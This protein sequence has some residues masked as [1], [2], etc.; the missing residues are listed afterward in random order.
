[1]RK[2][3]VTAATF[4]PIDVELAKLR[5]ELR[6][7]GTD[8]D[9]LLADFILSAAEA[10][11][12]FTNNVLCRS[13]WDLYLDAFPDSDTIETPGPLCEHTLDSPPV[14]ATS[15]TYY[16]ES[17]VL[18]TLATTVYKVDVTDPLCGRITLKYG[19]SWP[20]TY[21]E[22]NVVIVRFTAGYENSG[23]IKRSVKDGL[24]AKVQELYDGVDRAPIYYSLWANSRRV[25]F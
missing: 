23:A 14:D 5:P 15:I 11:E 20:S 22:T 18:Q 2:V 19:Q 13:T 10:Y 4:M 1:M 17:N 8:D 21:S 25:P 12:E 3:L 9:L 6:L 7:E 24:M 16:D